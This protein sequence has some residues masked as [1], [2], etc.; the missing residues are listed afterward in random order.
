[1]KAG[2][3]GIGALCKAGG[4]PVPSSS[5]LGGRA[6]SRLPGFATC[7]AAAVARQGI[8]HAG[9]AQGNVDIPWHSLSPQ[10]MAG[11]KVPGQRNGVSRDCFQPEGISEEAFFFSVLLVTV[12]VF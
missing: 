10:G 9:A 5:P 11:G 3:P 2:A 6:G 7:W 8:F 4:P 12:V 1:M